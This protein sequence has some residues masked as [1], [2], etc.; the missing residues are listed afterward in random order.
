[1]IDN[2][3]YNGT[4][5]F[6]I[7]SPSLYSQINCTIYRNGA[8]YTSQVSRINSLYTLTQS[9]SYSIKYSAVRTAGSQQYN[10]PERTLTFTIVNPNESRLALDF[11]TLYNSYIIDK[12]YR[13]DANGAKDVTA[14][15]R[16]ILRDH[17]MITS[18][19][20]SNNASMLGLGQYRVEYTVSNR[21]NLPDITNIFTFRISNQ[22]V[23][24]YSSLTPGKS[25]TKDVTITFNPYVIY[26]QLGECTL[27]IGDD[28]T[29]NINATSAADSTVRTLTISGA[30]T[31]YVQLLGV[32]D[33]VLNIFIVQSDEP[34]NT[35]AIILIIVVSVA[36]VAGGITFLVLRH[37]M[38]VR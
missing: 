18:Q 23:S 21:N 1:M 30:G 4:V 5:I 19:D 9:G 14:I 3:Y 10:I 34:L 35:A 33:S 28:L 7:L 36:V 6:E 38:K 29:Y 22:S 31:Y 32:D 13:M 15:F 17:T 27:R 24:I 37:R 26:R 12:V 2:A 25:T 11:T 20:L 8:D 16:D